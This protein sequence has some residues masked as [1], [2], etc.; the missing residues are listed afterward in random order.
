MFGPAH[1]FLEHDVAFTKTTYRYLNETLTPVT[2]PFGF[3]LS[4]T[5]FELSF[6]GPPPVP[7]RL[8]T[9]GSGPSLQVNVTAS[10]KG[11]LTGDVVVQVYM[12]PP[13]T[14]AVGGKIK[15]D[16]APA[17]RIVAP[18]RALVAYRRLKNVEVNSTATAGF[19]LAVQ[20][21]LVATVVRGT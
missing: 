4:L 21:L 15:A 5:V 14:F 13:A 6:E 17:D 16:D 8:A 11:P 9:D 7:A 12:H 20:D 3:G 2:F 1:D 18:N 19:N 10:N